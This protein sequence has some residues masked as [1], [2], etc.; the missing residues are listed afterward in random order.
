MGGKKYLL[1]CSPCHAGNGLGTPATGI[2]PLAGSEW[3]KTQGPGRAIRI[4]LH[5][6]R[7]PITVAGRQF[8]NPGMLAWDPA[9]T[10]KDIP[11]ILSYVP[12]NNESGHKASIVH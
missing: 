3:G 6:I 7:G 1:F 8:D 12:A 11:A 10:D 9:L 4:V 5:A 2:P